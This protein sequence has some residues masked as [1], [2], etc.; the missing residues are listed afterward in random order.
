MEEGRTRTQVLQVSEELGGVKS[1]ISEGDDS[2]GG[3]E[4]GGEGTSHSGSSFLRLSSSLRDAV[5][6]NFATPTLT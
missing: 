6:T 3:G 2:A 1:S 4:G 5:A